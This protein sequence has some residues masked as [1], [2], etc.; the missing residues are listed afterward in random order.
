MTKADLKE[1][2]LEQA[3]FV[4]ERSKK[5]EDVKELIM[6]TKLMYDIYNNL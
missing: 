6:L 2:L 4:G 1:A 3:M 5:T